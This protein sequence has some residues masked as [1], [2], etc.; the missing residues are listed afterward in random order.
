VFKKYICGDNCDSFLDNF[1]NSMRDGFMLNQ[2]LRDIDGKAISF[3]ILE[4]NKAFEKL[5]KVSREDIL[6][7]PITEVFEG[8]DQEWINICCSVE[9]DRTSLQKDVYF[10]GIDRHFRVNIISQINDQFIVLL[11]DITELIKADEALKKHFMLFEYAKDIIF[12]LKTDGSILDA[13]KTA[14]EHYGY[15]KSE[16]LNMKIQQIRDSSTMEAF[17]E[18]MQISA[19]R[20]IVF[21]SMHVKKDGTVFPVEV[22]SRTLDIHGELIRFHIARDITDSK[23]A[24]EKIKYFANYDTLTGIYNRGYLMY[25]LRKT[26]EQANIENFQF[27]VMLFD[28]DKFKVINDTFGHHAGDEVLKNV[29]SRLREAV[30]N[31]DII[32]RLGGDEFLVVQPFIKDTT[33]PLILAK[34]ILDSISKPVEWEG[35]TLD[36]H[37]SIGIS[38]YPESS[39][40]LKGLIHCA[41]S[42][43][44]SV[45]QNGGNSYN[46]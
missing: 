18:Q 38:I 33:D 34:K 31:L 36:I 43:M 7:K 17:E 11:N 39:D 14:V 40:N 13:N 26:L 20:G 15:T 25:Q 46:Y 35:N 19:S 42:A 45:K 22:S 29:A 8:I 1:L 23:K 9:L 5:F 24:E 28:L 12:Y 27:A 6:G 41:D 32:G 37:V 4:I 21:E 16:L 10:K 3:S 30:R 44:Y 2:L